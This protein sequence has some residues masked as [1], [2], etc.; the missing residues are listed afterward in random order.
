MTV[1]LWQ[2]GFAEEM[3]VKGAS[4]ST[5]VMDCVHKFVMTGNQTALYPLQV[6][7]MFNTAPV[8]GAR[9]QEFS[10]GLNQGFA[11]TLAAHLICVHAVS[12]LADFGSV[13]MWQAEDMRELAD[14]IRRCVAMQGTYEPAP[15]IET[16]VF[17]AISSKKQVCQCPL[18]SSIMKSGRPSATP[19]LFQPESSTSPP[20]HPSP[21]PHAR[22]DL[23]I[24]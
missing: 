11:T 10:V 19:A 23:P 24:W 18:R 8:Q 9:V 17:K 15:N 14:R 21:A 5:D 22:L 2:L 4:P 1:G 12:S 20:C 3:A 6:L 13:E 16:Q 7:H